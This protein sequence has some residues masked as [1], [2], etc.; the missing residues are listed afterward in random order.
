MPWRRAIGLAAVVVMGC[1]DDANDSGWGGT[2]EVLANGARLVR[3]PAEGVRG[4]GAGSGWR[5]VEELR[6]GRVEGGGPAEFGRIV[7]L[8]V[9]G[10]GRLW[11]VEGQSQE[12]RVFDANGAHVRTVGG[13]GSGPGEFRSVGG[14]AWDG[15][16]DLWV[17]DG[18]NGRYTRYDTAGTLRET[19]PRT[20]A[21][22]PFGSWQGGIRDDGWLYDQDMLPLEG[23]AGVSGPTVP[24]LLAAAG[25]AS[26]DRTILRAMFDTDPSAA[27][28][29]GEGEGG[30]AAAGEGTSERAGGDTVELPVQR[31]NLEPFSVEYATERGRGTRFV[32]V[33]FAPRLHRLFDPRGYLWFGESDVYRIHQ[34]RLEGD[35][36]LIIERAYTR[37]PVRSAELD[38]WEAGVA[39]FG[40]AG[41]RIDRSRIPSE[42]PVF[43][44]LMV[45]D[46]GHLWVRLVGDGDEPVFDVFDAAGRYLGEVTGAAGLALFPAPVIRGE[47]FYSVVH[48][49]LDVPWVVR[50]RIEGR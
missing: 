23:A 26:E 36:L 7:G 32:G 40:E 5:L 44:Q 31:T 25:I 24:P 43:D 37:L 42:K 17:H 48:D 22:P 18:Q 21:A 19:Q 39:S 15:A 38:E 13:R 16:G 9:D 1:G 20:T 35:T 14:L 34:R 3:N 46:R 33:P 29:G 11:V 30:G 6:V 50:Y 4:G 2:E 8:E 41:G 12:L 28:S 10:T 47:R 45:N 27:S 49:S